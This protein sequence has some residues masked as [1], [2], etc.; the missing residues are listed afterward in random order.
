M[1]DFQFVIQQLPIKELDEGPDHYPTVATVREVDVEASGKW[2]SFFFSRA[3]HFINLATYT[4]GFDQLLKDVQRP[5]FDFPDDASNRPD[6]PLTPLSLNNQGLTYV[7]YKL[8]DKNWQFCR[9]HPPF[10][11]GPKLTGKKIY[12]E[13][14][15]LTP[16]G[17]KERVIQ[18]P[19]TEE[20]SPVTDDCAVAYFIAD[21]R[22]ALGTTGVYTHA[23]NIHVDLVFPGQVP[24]YTPL[25]IDPDV[26]HPGGSGA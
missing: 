24:A 1:E 21:G 5:D 17:T 11:I 13:A 25:I 16:W 9:N 19:T 12:C 7:I 18:N 8:S 22:K 10:S 6:P 15:R 23:I 4:G 3:N 2:V 20:W 26:R 14:R